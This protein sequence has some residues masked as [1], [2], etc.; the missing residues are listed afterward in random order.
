MSRS[1][2]S[3]FDGYHKWL[4]IPKSKS[5]SYYDILALSLDE[6]D[7]DVIQ[8]AV[9][10]R[11]HF[12]ESKRGEGHD[13][14]VAEILYQINE[15]EVTLLNEEL[16]R[17]YD[18]RM[19]LFEKRRKN[20]QIDPMAAS[21]RF[22]S[23]PGRVVGEDNGFVATFA[24]LVGVICLAFAIMA[25]FSFKLPWQKQEQQTDPTP[26]AQ[27]E[28]P[29]IAVSQP[30]PIPVQAPEPA[31][32]VDPEPKDATTEAM[33]AIQ[34]E[35]RCIASEEGGSP[36]D[37][38]TM[39]EQD[40][41]VIINGTTFVMNRLYDGIRKE[42][43]GRFTINASNRHF[44]FV[45]KGPAGAPNEWL[46]IH[47]LDG[48]T[49]KLCFRY[50]TGAARPTQFKTD[51]DRANL[52]GFYTFV[53]IGSEK[54]KVDVSA[55][56]SKALR[57][58]ITLPQSGNATIKVGPKSDVP[59][60]EV[61]G[62]PATLPTA[63]TA[64]EI[65]KVDNNHAIDWEFRQVKDLSDFKVLDGDVH[66]EK[67]NGSLLFVPKDRGDGHFQADL[68]WPSF[69]TLPML[70][71]FDVDDIGNGGSIVL[72]LSRQSTNNVYGTTEFW[73]KA[74]DSLT[75][76]LKMSVRWDSN[77]GQTLKHLIP[78]KMVSTD[79]VVET[80]FSLD[81]SELTSGNRFTLRFGVVGKAPVGLSRLSL[82][83]HLLQDTEIKAFDQEVASVVRKKL[84]GTKWSNSN[85]VSF[86]WTKDG[87]FLHGGK[88]RKWEV[89][90]NRV[91]ITF[92][93][94]HVDTLYF[95]ASFTEF[96]QL[97]RGGPEKFKGK[98]VK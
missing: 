69:L 71:S 13:D 88:E 48:D 9:E 82:N 32:P 12:V 93:P 60:V 91:K 6:E 45:G 8:A 19:A 16:R 44:D 70:I 11:R 33:K 81:K 28:E 64:S 50:K 72:V 87:R 65:R 63:T 15:A 51:T 78:E 47:E 14:V 17:E 86:V 55:K 18:R 24:G 84:V 58:V 40:R 80:S 57:V 1:N 59:L 96:T 25:W 7:H 83:S 77:N 2:Q 49:L 62:E 36:L 22:K 56:A 67:G 41:R 26:I 42:Y 39:R 85:N 98:L 35:W 21:T 3:D 94:D 79:T 76:P 46:G 38:R 34:G 54:S 74:D 73:L 75:S 4:G 92:S 20:R 68:H 66:L 61:T 27:A 97:V 5:R 29:A 95:N 31:K 23:R 37:E 53:R 52:S 10:Q 43:V 30:Q 90:G 89:E